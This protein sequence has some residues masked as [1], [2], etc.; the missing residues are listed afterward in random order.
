VG[1]LLV[2][3]QQAD[4][5]SLR[6][7]VVNRGNR[8]AHGARPER[9]LHAAVGQHAFRDADPARRRD[10]RLGTSRLQRVEVGPC[11]PPDLEHILEA[12]RGEQH[13]PGAAALEQ[14]VRRHGRSV[15]Q[16]RPRSAG[17]TPEAV[18][19]RAGR[20]VGCR[21][22]LQDGQAA[23]DQ[24]DEIG[25][26]AAGVGPDDNPPRAQVAGDF[27]SDFDSVLDSVLEPDLVSV[28]VSLVLLDV[29]LDALESFAE[30]LAPSLPPFLPARA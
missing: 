24:R 13:H 1:G 20:I 12:A 10:E 19:N 18:G 28:L 7:E 16:Q 21:S 9:E 26:S 14:G 22:D 4:R 15:V 25:E 23:T 8:P 3:V 29:S 5:D 11:L 30:S 2:A 27:V 17:E 6:A